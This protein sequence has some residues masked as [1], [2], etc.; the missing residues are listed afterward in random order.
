MRIE[1]SVD[2]RKAIVFFVCFACERRQ[3]GREEGENQGTRGVDRGSEVDR[4]LAH[5]PLICQ[6]TSHRLRDL[7]TSLRLQ[8]SHLEI[9]RLSHRCISA[10]CLLLS[11]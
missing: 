10:G 5:A 9:L 4:S 1:G 2:V 8:H 6:R 7:G 11:I 3:V